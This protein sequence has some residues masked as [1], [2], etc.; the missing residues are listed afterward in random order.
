MRGILSAYWEGVHQ[1]VPMCFILNKTGKEC[2][3]KDFEGTLECNTI[4]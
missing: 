4:I 2:V 1:S 3:R